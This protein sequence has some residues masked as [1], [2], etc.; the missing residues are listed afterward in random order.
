MSLIAFRTV[1]ATAAPL[2]LQIVSRPGAP[3]LPVSTGGYDVE[4][5][6]VHFSYRPDMPILKGV[7]FSVPAGSTCAIVGTSGSGKSTLFRLLYRFYDPCSGS[8]RLAGRDVRDW[9]L[10]SMRAPLAAVP[11]DVVL[12]N[13]TI[14][15]NIAYGKPGCTDEEIVA[16]A[17]DAKLHDAVMAMP[18][19]YDTQVGERGLKVSGGEKQRLALARA[20]LKV[21]SP[22]RPLGRALLA[23]CCFTRALSCVCALR[24]PLPCPLHA[25]LCKQLCTV[26][27][28]CVSR[29]HGSV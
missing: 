3:P 11:Q 25:W 20:F 18:Q 14:R 2:L 26:H 23:A 16:A 6:D 21:R 10:Q 19:G 5:Q 8:V 13:D 28:F 4:F 1:Q 22:S 7:T 17:R 12:F 24:S 29:A 27:V 15:Y 9:D